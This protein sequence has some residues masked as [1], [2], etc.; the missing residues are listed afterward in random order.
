MIKIS[1]SKQIEAFV[2]LLS[3]LSKNEEMCFLNRK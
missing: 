1:N 2:R 3:E